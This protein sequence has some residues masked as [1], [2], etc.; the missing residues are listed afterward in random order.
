MELI[1]NKRT[2]KV[3]FIVEGGK[4]EFSLIKKIFVDILDFTQIEKRRGGAKFYKRNSSKRLPRQSDFDWNGCG[5][6]MEA[7]EGNGEIPA[8]NHLCRHYIR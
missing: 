4:H 7:I 5:R 1:K 3:L 8:P 2:G 6:W